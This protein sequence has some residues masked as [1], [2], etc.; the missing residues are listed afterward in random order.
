MLVRPEAQPDQGLT[1]ALPDPAVVDRTASKAASLIPVLLPY[2]QAWVSDSSPVKVCVKSRRI[3]I[4]WAVACEA[5]FLASRKR[6]QGGMDVWYLSQSERD[7]KE[8]I[9]DCATWARVVDLWL[10]K[11]GSKAKTTATRPYQCKVRVLLDDGKTS[12]QATRIKFTSGHRITILPGKNPDVL[13]GK[14][15][16]VIF[17]EAALLDIDACLRAASALKMSMR[18]GRIAFIS[19]QRGEANGFNKLVENVRAEKRGYKHYKLH[20]Y[21]LRDAIAQGYY[22]RRCVMQG[23]PYSKRREK[24]FF[25]DCMAEPGAAQEYDC[26]PARDGEQ[27]FPR[28]LIARCQRKGRPQVPL[29]LPSG[30]ETQGT[31][32]SRAEFVARWCERELGPLLERLVKWEHHYIGQDFGRSAEGDLSAIAILALRDDKVRRQQIR[33]VPL[34]VELTGVP[35]PQQ[36]QILEYIVTRLPNFGGGKWDGQGNGSSTAEFAV[37]TFGAGKCES[38]KPSRQWYEKWVPLVKGAM[39]LEELEIPDYGD[40]MRDFESFALDDSVPLLPKRRTKGTHGEKRHGDAAMAV[41]FAFAASKQ[42][43]TSTKYVGQVP[44]AKPKI[45]AW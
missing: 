42:P 38:V 11:K 8:F 22:R 24:Q 43:T 16:Y 27:Y 13:R 9:R 41:I 25:E 20:E 35:F 14:Q 5:V 45:T 2:Q 15:G 29:K 36:E 10:S 33:S 40:L 4:S 39:Q 17:D 30:W 32:E 7:A 6:D 37:T 19:T 31:K 1:P 26:V 21:R 34:I 18:A 23:I 12:V 28:D 44:S 3:G